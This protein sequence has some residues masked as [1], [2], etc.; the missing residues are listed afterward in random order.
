[1]VLKVQVVPSGELP[2]R[3]ES[4][5]ATYPVPLDVIAVQDSELGKVLA[6]QVVPSADTAALFVPPEALPRTQKLLP[7]DAMLIQ[8]ELEGRLYEVQVT[9]SGV[10]STVLPLKVAPAL[11][12]QKTLPFQATPLQ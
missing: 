1:M 3:F 12:T 6:V 8:P 9:P 2:H 5:I 10:V 4:A 11:A 7:L